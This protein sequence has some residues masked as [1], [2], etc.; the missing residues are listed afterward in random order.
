MVLPRA[1]ELKQKLRQRFNEEKEELEAELAEKV[2]S[3]FNIFPLSVLRTQID[4][5]QHDKL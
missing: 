3:F 5:I 1:M 2:S 4:I